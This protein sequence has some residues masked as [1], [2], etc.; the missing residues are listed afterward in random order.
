MRKAAI[1]IVALCLIVAGAGLAW[2]GLTLGARTQ[3]SMSWQGL[4]PV[5][6]ARYALE[7]TEI[8][9]FGSVDVACDLADVEFFP[10]DAWTLEYELFDLD[11]EPEWSVEG[12]VLQVRAVS[13]SSS[14]INLSFGSSGRSRLRVGFPEGSEFTDVSI[15]SD[16]GS[17]SM[18]GV[19][20]QSAQITLDVG[21]LDMQDCS[22]GSAQITMDLGDFRATGLVT[23]S[24]DIRMSLGALT[25]HGCDMSGTSVIT[26]K[27]GDVLIE[28][29]VTGD[30]TAANDIGDID[31]AV[32]GD[33]GDY[34]YQLTV[35]LGSIH[36]DGREQGKSAN[37]Q[38]PGAK[39]II[40]A[41][42]DLGS[43]H[44]RFTR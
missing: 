3:Y 24:A 2:T 15:V 27:Q 12:G 11:R 8:G 4:R 37:V 17:L 35:D 44:V 38:A 22:F 18:A 9:A 34:S 30:F 28:G 41:T 36:V 6:Q 25:V 29:A 42:C 32:D 16:L 19:S 23:K 10:S 43:I 7:E 5:E 33:K 26:A 13:R 31:L 14:S 40:R 39:N 21:S 20:A 1:W